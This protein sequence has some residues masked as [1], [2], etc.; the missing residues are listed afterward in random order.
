[1][2][3]FGGLKDIT[4]KPEAVHFFLIAPEL[5]RLSSRAEEMSG[6]SHKK[7]TTHTNVQERSA[8]TRS[9]DTET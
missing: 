8:Q 3:V 6:L 1:M 2:K 7:R 9:K 4:Q 5:E